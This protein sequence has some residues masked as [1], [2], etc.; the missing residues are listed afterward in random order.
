MKYAF[1]PTAEDHFDRLTR[2]TRKRIATKMRFYATQSDPLKFAE[3]LT[4]LSEY[5]FRVGDYRLPRHL[6]GAPRHDL[7]HRDQTARRGL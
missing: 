3:P 6:R 1:T 5:R 4:G 7:G 2:Q